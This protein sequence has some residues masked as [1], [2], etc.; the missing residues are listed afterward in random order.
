MNN[1]VFKHCKLTLKNDKNKD[2]P[3]IVNYRL[4]VLYSFSKRL[5]ALVSM[6]LEYGIV[7]SQCHP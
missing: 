7:T 4:E 6:G 2:K 1:V 5:M 3:C